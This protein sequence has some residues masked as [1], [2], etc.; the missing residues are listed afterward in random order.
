[1]EKKRHHYIPKTYLNYFCNEQGKVRVYRK[2]D[3]ENSFLQSPDSTGFHKYYYSQP[4]PDGGKDNNALEDLFSGYEWKWPNIVGRIKKRENVNDSLEDIFIFM[5]LQRARVPA[6]RDAIEKLYA[7]RVKSTTRVLDKAGVLPPKPDGYED[8]LDK[9]HVAIDPHLSIHRM[10]GIV[11]GAARVFSQIGIG[12]FHNK[13]DIQFLTSDNPVIWF[14]PSVP[15]KKMK[16]YVLQPGGP[17]AVVFP[18]TPDLLIYGDSSMHE[19]FIHEGL[20][21]ATLRNRHHVKFLNKNISKFAYNTVF[22]QKTGNEPVIRKYAEISPVLNTI[23]VQTENGEQI[24]FDNIFGERSNKPKW[25][26]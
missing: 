25:K 9:A 6:S 19:Q 10:V 24:Q 11:Q 21:H 12:V 14:D 7:E 2:D 4:L 5:G 1:M 22:A 18:I 8:I 13:T 20:T 15:D 26:E 3:P 16:P 23:V 17:V